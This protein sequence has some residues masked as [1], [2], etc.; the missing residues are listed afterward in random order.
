MQIKTTLAALAVAVAAT[1]CAGISDKWNNRPAQ[2]LRPGV[3]GNSLAQVH[4]DPRDNA[5]L[6]LVDVK[7]PARLDLAAKTVELKNPAA[8]RYVKQECW[9]TVVLRTWSKDW[10]QDGP[11]LQLARDPADIETT[12]ALDVH[13]V[14][15]K[16]TAAFVR[17]DHPEAAASFREFYQQ[18][19]GMKAKHLSGCPD[20][21]RAVGYEFW[22]AESAEPSWYM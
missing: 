17:M 2:E 3:G 1:G 13:R 12:G 14:K 8:V 21:I 5:C 10:P 4:K 22:D 20:A 15:G 16:C 7:S 9:G 6:I 19:D 11:A 18:R